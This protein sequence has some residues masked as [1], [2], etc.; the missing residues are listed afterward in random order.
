MITDQLQLAVERSGPQAHIP[1]GEEDRG[2]ETDTNIPSPVVCECVRINSCVSV[3]GK[4][5]SHATSPCQCRV[6]VEF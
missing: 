3:R 4:T 5:R 2:V 6:V 1:F